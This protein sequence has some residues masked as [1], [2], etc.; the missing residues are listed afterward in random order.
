M[1]LFK[2]DLAQSVVRGNFDPE[3]NGSSP[4]FGV[5]LSKTLFS[6]FRLPIQYKGFEV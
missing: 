6:H 1:R 5:C 3:V 4:L 2:H